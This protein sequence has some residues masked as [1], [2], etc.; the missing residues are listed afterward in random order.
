MYS[1]FNLSVFIRAKSVSIRGKPKTFGDTRL[2]T[3]KRD[4][5]ESRP[6]TYS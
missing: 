5:T 2:I 3:L 6:W 4:M 1:K